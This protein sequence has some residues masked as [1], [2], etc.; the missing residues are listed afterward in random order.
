V[1]KSDAFS[2]LIF[3][4]NGNS[5]VGEYENLDVAVEVVDGVTNT[6]AQST[7][8]GFLSTDGGSTLNTFNISGAAATIPYS[9]KGNL[10]SG[11]YYTNTIN[12]PNWFYFTQRTSEG[13]RG[14]VHNLSNG[15]TQTFAISNAVATQATSLIHGTTNNLV[16]GTAY[17]DQG[18]S[19]SSRAFIYDLDSQTETLLDF[20]DA[21]FTTFFAGDNG[22]LVGAYAHDGNSLLN[23]RLGLGPE[24]EMGQIKGLLYE[25]ETGIW[26]SLS[27]PDPLDSSR[28][29]WADTWANSIEG[30][31]IVGTAAYYNL[32]GASNPD[33]N[34]PNS[35]SIQAFVY[36]VPEPG[37]GALVAVVW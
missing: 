33:P 9:V 35:W 25:M 21:E 22:R 11:T 23:P 20:P 32:E 16:V 34:D 36:T 28:N 24:Y 13:A 27:A 3:G 29:T 1:H 5:L 6:Y 26:T 8:R 30:D 10:I 12:E 14:F 19:L 37:G 2:T 15:V 18:G 4:I 7:Y 17:F 31:T